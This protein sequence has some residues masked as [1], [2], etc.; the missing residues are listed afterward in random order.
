MST[1]AWLPEGRGRPW[2]EGALALGAA[3]ATA[4][5]V[6]GSGGSAVAA[7]APALVLVTASVV[8]VLPVRTTIFALIFL[9]L[10][11]DLP[12]DAMGYW[13]SPLAPLGQLLLSNLNAT[14]PIPSLKISVLSLAIVI[15]FALFLLR[16]A[17]GATL[18][19]G[20][21]AARPLLLGLGLSL[22]SL[23][24]L[25]AFGLA[26]GGDL[27]MCNLQGQTFF[28]L[29]LTAYLLARSLRGPRDYAMLACLVVAAGCVKALLAVWIRM[30]VTV[31]P[32]VVLEYAT[33]H[34]DSLTFACAAALVAAL[35][36]EEP[37]R[38]YT[39]PALVALS[40]LLAGMVANTRRLAWVQLG[41]ALLVLYL[42][43]PM[44]RRKRALRRSMLYA[45]P[46]LLLYLGAGW[47]SGSALFRPV[48]LVRSLSD[49][50][51]DRSTWFRDVE[52]FNLVQTA[53]Q[54]PF[55]G[56]G[57]GHPFQEVVVPVDITDVFKEYHYLPHNS[58]LGLWAFGGL[59]GFTGLWA[60][61]TIAVV[62]AARA[63]RQASV[64]GER[65]AAFMAI[66][67]VVVYAI[68]CWGDIGFSERRTILL[69]GPGLA[70]AG[71]VA[72]ATPP[73]VAA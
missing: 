42:L 68:H 35:W 46:V 22:L 59:L 70:I 1:A 28:L 44:T 66:V 16:R 48:H 39:V 50:G 3:A 37:S 14:I 52:N 9:G 32:P 31:P 6:I 2:A 41:A 71:Q 53:K 29:L 4:L 62:L 33:S 69:V 56:T 73:R 43:S 20:R 17:V 34:A 45:L 36:W 60:P 40:V 7:V 51:T 15:L 13:I 21:G 61:L 58:L 64:P 23:I 55:L 27:R 12:G 24:G 57:F 54:H 72:L 19:E 8:W 65:V 67:S 38:R 25:C 49:P 18:D 47:R 11:L 63:Y 10:S 30:T 26:R 5:V